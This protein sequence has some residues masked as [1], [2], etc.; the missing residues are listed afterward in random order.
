MLFL[1][2]AF[3]YMPVSGVISISA[4]RACGAAAF[5]DGRKKLKFSKNFFFPKSFFF[6]F[7]S[8]ASNSCKF[9]A[10]NSKCCKKK[11][12]GR[13]SHFLAKNVRDNFF[14]SLT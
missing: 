3:V 10:I 5:D 4:I 12:S 11:V 13:K 9:A 1:K 6:K 2:P 8:N 7:L 14:K